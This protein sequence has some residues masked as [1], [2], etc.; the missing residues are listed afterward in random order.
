MA[1]QY[2]IGDVTIFHNE[3]YNLFA[4]KKN[5]QFIDLHTLPIKTIVEDILD[6]SIYPE[7]FPYEDLERVAMSYVNQTKELLSA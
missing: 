6:P 4:V 3:F 5:G 7:G 1:E 2:V